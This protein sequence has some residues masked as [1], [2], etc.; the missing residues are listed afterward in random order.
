[1]RLLAPGPRLAAS[2]ALWTLLKSIEGKPI[3]MAV[4]TPGGHGGF[5]SKQPVKKTPDP[6]ETVAAVRAS[7]GLHETRGILHCPTRRT[8]CLEHMSSFRRKLKHLGQAARERSRS[9]VVEA[10]WHG[11]SRPVPVNPERQC[12]AHPIHLDSGPLQGMRLAWALSFFFIAQWPPATAGPSTKRT[13]KGQ[14]RM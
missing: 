6:M 13:P 7:H 8:V 1:M 5:P 10:S 4:V 12:D 9:A 14:P 11:G 2:S 3:P